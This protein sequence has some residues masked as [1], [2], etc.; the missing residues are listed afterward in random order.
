MSDDREISLRERVKVLE[1]SNVVLKARV[2][3]LE[4]EHLFGVGLMNQISETQTNILEEI[5]KIMPTQEVIDSLTAKLNA[6]ASK[7]EDAVK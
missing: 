6:S 1:D 7:L 3:R 4:N 2:E 5:K